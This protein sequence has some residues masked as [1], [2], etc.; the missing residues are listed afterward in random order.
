MMGILRAGGDAR[1]VMVN[2]IIFLW[3]L[4]VPLGFFTGLVWHWPV[5]IVYCILNL[6]QF[7]K[8][9]TSGARL[10]GNKWM[11]QVTVTEGY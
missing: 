8:L 10:H 6:E 3:T 4:E 7:I 11:K 1:F 9:F 5:P 2:D